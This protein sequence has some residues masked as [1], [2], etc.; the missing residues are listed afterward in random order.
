MKGLSRTMNWTHP[1]LDTIEIAVYA[2]VERDDLSCTCP[3]I[4]N[5]NP[6]NEITCAADA[7]T[8]NNLAASGA[9]VP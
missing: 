6:L 7:S 2:S 3:T 5:L 8:P 4:D 9:Q 1:H